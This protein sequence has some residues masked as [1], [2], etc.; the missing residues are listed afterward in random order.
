MQVQIWD[1]KQQGSMD[2]VLCISQ[3][4]DTV[5]G[6][7]AGIVCFC[8]HEAVTVVTVG[9]SFSGPSWHLVHARF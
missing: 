9:M 4:I 8:V 3:G 7:I 2:P 5:V 6:L 1:A